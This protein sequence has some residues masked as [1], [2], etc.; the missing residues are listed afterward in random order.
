MPPNLKT[1]RQQLIDLYLLH[2]ST[3]HEQ[4]RVV[5]KYITAFNKV[6]KQNPLT[7]LEVIQSRFPQLLLNHSKRN[8]A[9]LILENNF[10]KL[11]QNLD[12]NGHA[13]FNISAVTDVYSS[14]ASVALEHIQTGVIYKYNQN[15]NWYSINTILK[16]QFSFFD[17][18]P[19]ALFQEVHV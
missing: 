5:A 19:L 18:I 10:K 11:I 2:N 4:R 8:L 16:D 3:S 17:K 9:P 14:S 7:T 12:C 6:N 13:L 1:E 15:Y